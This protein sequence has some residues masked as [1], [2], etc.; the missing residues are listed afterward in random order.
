MKPEEIKAQP[1]LIIYTSNYILVTISCGDKI[2]AVCL[3]GSVTHPIPTKI[4][5]FH[6][7]NL[8]DFVKKYFPVE[9]VNFVGNYNNVDNYTLFD[10]SEE[11][12]RINKQ[13]IAE[14]FGVTP[15]YLEISE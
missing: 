9:R 2:V 4:Y 3:D 5:W 10:R 13:Q 7:M 14:K 15:E 6:E 1:N 8:A 12:L 11:T